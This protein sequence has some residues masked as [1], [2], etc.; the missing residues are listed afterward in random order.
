MKL[1]M[2]SHNLT[3]LTNQSSYEVNNSHEQPFP[4]I[5]KIDTYEF[6][7]KNRSPPEIQ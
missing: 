6:L 1:Y 5:L 3:T 2:E 4:I 7:T